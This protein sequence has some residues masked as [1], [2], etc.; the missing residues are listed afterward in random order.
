MKKLRKQKSKEGEKKNLMFGGAVS[1]FVHHGSLKRFIN[2]KEKVMVEVNG[3]SDVE[4]E[5]N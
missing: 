3:R 2:L 4:S 1:N 5:L